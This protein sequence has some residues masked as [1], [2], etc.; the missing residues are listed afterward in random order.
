MTLLDEARKNQEIAKERE[1]N[2]KALN[3]KLI[4]A[5]ALKSLLSENIE[6]GTFQERQIVQNE[7][8][9]L[10]KFIQSEKE[11]LNE[12]ATDDDVQDVLKQMSF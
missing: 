8:N 7:I 4:D 6:I 5:R 12:V 11:A 3:D 10:E 2:L 1:I 9:R